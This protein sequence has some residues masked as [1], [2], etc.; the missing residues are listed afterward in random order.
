MFS[1]PGCGNETAPMAHVEKEAPHEIR[2]FCALFSLEEPRDLR[3]LSNRSPPICAL[4]I[5][6]TSPRYRLYFAAV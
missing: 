3:Q 2:A 1:Q 5:G 4:G 6:Y